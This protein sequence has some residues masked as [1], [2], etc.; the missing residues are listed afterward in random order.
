MQRIWKENGERTRGEI[1]KKR[2]TMEE[3]IKDEEWRETK[4]R[5]KQRRGRKRRSGGGGGGGIA[6]IDNFFSFVSVLR[7]ALPP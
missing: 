7:G 3:K 1:D 6:L 5:N 4:E 2:K